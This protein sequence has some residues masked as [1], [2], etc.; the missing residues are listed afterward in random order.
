MMMNG[1]Y[2]EEIEA[3]R[4]E[5]LVLIDGQW[6]IYNIRLNFSSNFIHSTNGKFND[7]EGNIYH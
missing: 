4:Y 7:V 6:K 3:Q 2:G 5:A 1:S